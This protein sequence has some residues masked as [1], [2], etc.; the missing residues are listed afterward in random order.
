MT[1]RYTIFIVRM[2]ERSSSSGKTKFFSPSTNFRKSST[3]VES[4]K[5][6]RMSAGQGSVVQLGA[7]QVSRGGRKFRKMEQHM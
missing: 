1:A 4:E 3:Q 2:R 7:H 5:A 6:S